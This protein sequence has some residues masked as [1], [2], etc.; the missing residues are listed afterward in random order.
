MPKCA[1]RRQANSSSCWLATRR[2]TSASIHPSEGIWVGGGKQLSIFSGDDVLTGS[3]TEDFSPVAI[4]AGNLTGLS[5]V[6]GVAV[7]SDGTLY[8]LSGNSRGDIDIFAPS[9]L[10][11]IG[12]GS[13]PTNIAPRQVFNSGGEGLGSPTGIFFDG[14]L[15]VTY[16]SDTASGFPAIAHYTGAKLAA[17]QGSVNSPGELV[18]DD[19]ITGNSMQ[20][21]SPQGIVLNGSWYQSGSTITVVDSATPAI[22]TYTIPFSCSC[23]NPA[24]TSVVTG[25]NT[26]LN[27]PLGVA[28]DHSGNYYATNTGGS[29]SV[30]MFTS[31]QITT[32]GNQTPLQAT[33][34]LSGPGFGWVDLNNDL[35]IPN[36]ANNSMSVFNTPLAGSDSAVVVNAGSKTF[37][38]TPTAIVSAP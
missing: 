8:V 25:T 22:N 21:T 1:A 2:N 14:D 6:Q 35:I 29:G 37:L 7:G 5:N 26:M 32:G 30:I 24:P 27:S 36:S 11:T 9:D 12:G 23:E 17:V 3:G 34:S 38:S 13:G 10:A 28:L 19:T 4:M 20:L 15:F 33:N 16:A 31:S 18:P